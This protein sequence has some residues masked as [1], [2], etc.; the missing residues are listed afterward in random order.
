MVIGD[1]LASLCYYLRGLRKYSKPVKKQT[2]LKTMKRQSIYEYLDTKKTVYTS[3]DS[4]DLRPVRRRSEHFR[5][6]AHGNYEETDLMSPTRRDLRF[7]K[8]SHYFL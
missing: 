7:V 5:L 6:N 2:V 3:C 8:E 4:A 1:S